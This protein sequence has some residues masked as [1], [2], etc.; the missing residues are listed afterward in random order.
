VVFGDVRRT[1]LYEFDTVILTG[2]DDEYTRKQT[3]KPPGQAARL[4]MVVRETRD[5]LTGTER[6]VNQYQ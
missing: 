2:L 1:S 6:A 3:K 5:Y 4:R